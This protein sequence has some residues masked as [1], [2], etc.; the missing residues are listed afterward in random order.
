MVQA[1]LSAKRKV[2]TDKLR[3]FQAPAYA[4]D[5]KGAM[6]GLIEAVNRFDREHGYAL[7]PGDMICFEH[8]TM[9][10]DPDLVEAICEGHFLTRAQWDALP[11]NERTEIQV[12]FVSGMP[13][14]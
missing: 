2:L 5:D 9:L 14:F 8:G 13:S 3:P 6:P 10:D 1:E 11:R 12:G 7:Q 4:R